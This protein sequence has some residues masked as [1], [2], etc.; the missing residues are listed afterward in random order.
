MIDT[1][2]VV[3]IFVIVLVTALLVVLGIQVFF[4]LKEIRGTVRRVNKVIDNAETITDS[5][6]QP[7]T[8]LSNLFTGGATMGPIVQI[9]KMFTKDRASHEK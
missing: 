5:F 3:L 4:I 6:S 9:L 1:V 2:Q 7:L 8:L